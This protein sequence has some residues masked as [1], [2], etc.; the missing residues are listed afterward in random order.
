MRLQLLTIF[1]MLAFA[2]NSLAAESSSVSARIDMMERQMIQMAGTLAKMKA[3]MRYADERLDSLIDMEIRLVR[4]ER[5]L[6]HVR[7]HAD[8]VDRGAPRPMLVPATW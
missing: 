7:R 4:M 1:A 3:D 6:R 5:D 2:G 8:Q